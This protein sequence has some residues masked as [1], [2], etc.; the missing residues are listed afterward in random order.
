MNIKEIQLKD[1]TWV[2]GKPLSRQKDPSGQL[3]H[4]KHRYPLQSPDV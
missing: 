1:V 4:M 2:P 3:S